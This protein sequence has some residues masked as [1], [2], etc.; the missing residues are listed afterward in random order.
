VRS[1]LDRLYV[2]DACFALTTHIGLAADAPITIPLQH[3]ASEITPRLFVV[4]PSRAAHQGTTASHF[5]AAVTAVGSMATANS[6]SSDWMTGW[7]R[8]PDLILRNATAFR[9][10][11]S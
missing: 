5:R 11:P 1:Y 8:A 4:E 6:H 7:L 2:V 3:D 10:S 9:A